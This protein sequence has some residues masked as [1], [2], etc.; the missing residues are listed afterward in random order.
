M[1]PSSK[2][3]NG[4]LP[5]RTLPNDASVIAC[6]EE[7]RSFPAEMSELQTPV[8]LW[9]LFEKCWNRNAMA[10]PDTEMCYKPLLRLVSFHHKLGKSLTT[11]GQFAN[12]VVVCLPNLPSDPRIQRPRRP[13]AQRCFQ[14]LIGA[15]GPLKVKEIAGIL[16]EV[17]TFAKAAKDD[18]AWEVLNQVATDVRST[19]VES[20]IRQRSE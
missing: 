10:R 14:Q 6:I 11:R 2:I 9:S 20:N 15:E 4:V 5:Y 8:D 17:A 16:D 12:A 13:L 18:D 7:G 3:L 1:M 19:H